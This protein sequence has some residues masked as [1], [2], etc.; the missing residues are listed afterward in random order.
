MEDAPERKQAFLKKS[1]DPTILW[2]HAR[3]EA[4]VQ[5]LETA[6][7]IPEVLMLTLN[8]SKKEY[9]VVMEKVEG[10]TLA[11]IPPELDEFKYSVEFAQELAKTF[12]RLE[13]T[14]I[15]HLDIHS[16]NV[17]YD[18]NNKRFVF[19]DVEELDNEH[20]PT[21]DYVA[22]YCRVLIDAYCGID[23]LASPGEIRGLAEESDNASLMAFSEE[24]RDED[25]A[26]LGFDR[27]QAVFDLADATGVRERANPHILN[28]LSESMSNKDAKSSSF[29]KL[30]DIP[31]IPLEK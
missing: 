28:F 8:P 30:F 4:L 1:D 22:D 20:H 7:L 11:D 5:K 27:P 15:Y 14:G 18:T 26:V 16:E 12:V 2:D 3:N 10:H 17:M 24:Y 25:N 23:I 21:S 6:G 9:Q 31:T 19:V 13:D 29:D